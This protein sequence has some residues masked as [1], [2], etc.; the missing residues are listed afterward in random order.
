MYT[1]GMLQLKKDVHGVVPWL[2]WLVP[3][4]SSKRLGF[5]PGPPSVEFVV[6]K[7]TRGPAFSKHIG[8]PS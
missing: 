8:F 6:D 3:G 2:R 7:L 4:L 1:T 5:D